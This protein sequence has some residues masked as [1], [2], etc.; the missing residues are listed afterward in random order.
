MAR[1]GMAGEQPVGQGQPQNLDPNQR[2]GANLGASPNQ[3]DQIQ[4]GENPGQMGNEPERTGGNQQQ[5]GNPGVGTGQYARDTDEDMDAPSMGDTEEDADEEE[6]KVNDRDGDMDD[7]TGSNA[8]AGS[9][10]Y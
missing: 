6:S 1:P 4:S 2:R 3:A 8:G 5:A 10:R 7:T 9:S